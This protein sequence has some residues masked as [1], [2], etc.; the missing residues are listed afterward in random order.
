MSFVLYLCV[1]FKIVIFIIY[2]INIM[3]PVTWLEVVKAQLKKNPGKSVKDIIPAARKQWAEI[4]KTLPAKKAAPK[5]TGK[6]KRNTK[7]RGRKGLKVTKGKRVTRGRKGKK[8]GTSKAKGKGK[9][10]RKRGRHIKQRGGN[11]LTDKLEAAG[12]SLERGADEVTNKMTGGD[13]KAEQDGGEQAAQDGGEQDGGDTATEEP[14]P[15][16][17]TKSE[18]FAPF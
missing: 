10:S 1:V 7:K 8:R 4:K 5:K 11:M 12:K 14:T 3:E 2:V 15:V 17:D 9:G 6:V 16:G 13:D 18:S